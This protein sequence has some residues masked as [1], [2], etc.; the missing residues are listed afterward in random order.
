MKEGMMPYIDSV[1]NGI[2]ERVSRNKIN[3][4]K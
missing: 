4:G 1:R 3:K 2:I